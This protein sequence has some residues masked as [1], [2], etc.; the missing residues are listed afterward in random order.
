M[1]TGEPVIQELTERAGALVDQVP[2]PNARQQLV[3]GRL[4]FALGSEALATQL[5]A[6]AR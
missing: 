4:G 6:L 3:K 5:S 2:G 1:L